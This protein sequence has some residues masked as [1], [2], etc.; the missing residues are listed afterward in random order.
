[1][2]NNKKVKAPLLGQQSLYHF[3]SNRFTKRVNIAIRDRQSIIFFDVINLKFKK[4][5]FVVL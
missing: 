5:R 2:L 4:R 3:K 1:M